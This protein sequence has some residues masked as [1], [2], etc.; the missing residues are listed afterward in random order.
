MTWQ[1]TWEMNASR[2]RARMCKGTDVHP[3]ICHYPRIEKFTDMEACD[4]VAKVKTLEMGENNG[5][6]IFC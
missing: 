2:Q 4:S 5:N 3:S 6:F 1:T